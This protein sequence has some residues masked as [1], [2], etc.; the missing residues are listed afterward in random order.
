MA[1]EIIFR[2]Y[3]DIIINHNGTAS[4]NLFSL[5][6]DINYD[7][8]TT[9]IYK[10]VQK[11]YDYNASATVNGTYM[12]TFGLKVLDTETG[13]PTGKVR[14][15]SITYIETRTSCSGNNISTMSDVSYCGISIDNSTYTYTTK[16]TTTSQSTNFST[17]DH[18]LSSQPSTVGKIYNSIDDVAM[19]VQVITY[20]YAVHN[21]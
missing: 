21:R 7:D 2:P 10:N 8:G 1:H 5:I 4:S 14:I 12:S 16:N 18:N 13:K 6:N 11:D 19:S 20:I 17:Y 3:S 15:N 9:Y